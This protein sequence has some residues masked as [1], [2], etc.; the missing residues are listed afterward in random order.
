M[1]HELECIYRSKWEEMSHAKLCMLA[2]RVDY[3]NRK[4]V[5]YYGALTDE[6]LVSEFVSDIGKQLDYVRGKLHQRLHHWFGDISN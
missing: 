3:L 4:L 2:N 5:D 1:G 6:Q